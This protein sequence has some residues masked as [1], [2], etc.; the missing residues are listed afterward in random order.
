MAPFAQIQ[1][2]CALLL[3]QAPSPPAGFRGPVSAYRCPA[4]QVNRMA[5]P[6]TARAEEC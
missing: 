2:V 4:P 3:A 5:W 6:L 1:K